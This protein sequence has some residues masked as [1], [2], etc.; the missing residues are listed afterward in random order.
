MLLSVQFVL[1]YCRNNFFLNYTPFT[2]NSTEY[3]TAAFI[4]MVEEASVVMYGS[5]IEKTFDVPGLDEC[6]TTKYVPSSL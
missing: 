3:C 6:D 2:V 4:C 1:E 5:L